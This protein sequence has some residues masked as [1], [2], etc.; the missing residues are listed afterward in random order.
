MMFLGNMKKRLI[1]A[2]TKLLDP[3]GPGPKTNQLTIQLY[4]FCFW[5]PLFR[6]W[7]ILRKILVLPLLCC[8]RLHV[9]KHL[10]LEW[11]EGSPQPPAV[12]IP[13]CIV[14]PTWVCVLVLIIVAWYF[15]A[16]VAFYMLFIE[17]QRVRLS[18]I[19]CVLIV[20]ASEGAERYKE[21]YREV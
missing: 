20:C 12:Y 19:Y 17:V 16:I 5:N 2:M 3:I 6:L 7:L 10:S 1:L 4:F 14:K 8:A 11:G 13:F 15:I 18:L 21:R 9:L